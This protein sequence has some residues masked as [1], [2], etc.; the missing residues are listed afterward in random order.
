MYKRVII[1]GLPGSGKTTFALKL[2]Q[3]L[4]IPLHHLDR[5]FFLANWV[6]RPKEDFLSIHQSLLDTPD[7]ILDGNAIH[8]LPIRYPHA[9]LILYF[10]FNRLLCLFRLI[11]R[12]FTSRSHV[13]DR[14]HGCREVLTWKLIRYMWTL[15][16]RIGPLL[17]KL[18]AQYPKPELHILT[19]QSEADRLLTS[20]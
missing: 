17:Q 20:M 19:S 5:H 1:L 16:A 2:A 14:A 13:Q 3:K 10:R 7:W 6:E 11:K 8:S 15:N 12:L 9:D 18:Q 4:N